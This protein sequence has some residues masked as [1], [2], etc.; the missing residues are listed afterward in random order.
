MISEG[1]RYGSSAG[2]LLQYLKRY[3]TVSIRIPHR[4][5]RGWQ[6]GEEMVGRTQC[7]ALE[8]HDQG[9]AHPDVDRDY[10]TKMLTRLFSRHRAA[11][12]A[13][14]GMRIASHGRVNR[15]MGHHDA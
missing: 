6:A 10:H 12:G 2:C 1:T 11:V 14:F 8:H 3:I 9:D 4:K 7:G 5:N 13:G 15:T